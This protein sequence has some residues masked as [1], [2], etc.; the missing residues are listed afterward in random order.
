MLVKLLL[1][2][3][4]LLTK[5]LDNGSEIFLKIY[6]EDTLKVSDRIKIYDEN[7]REFFF[8]VSDVEKSKEIPLVFDEILDEDIIV[9]DPE[10]KDT[11]FENKVLLTI[12]KLSWNDEIDLNLFWNQTNDVEILK[13]ILSTKNNDAFSNYAGWLADKYHSNIYRHARVI[14]KDCL[15]PNVLEAYLA[16]GKF[17]VLFDDYTVNVAQIGG[18]N[19]HEIFNPPKDT[20]P[21]L[22][23]IR[24]SRKPCDPKTWYEESTSLKFSK[25]LQKLGIKLPSNFT[26]YPNFY[27]EYQS[28]NRFHIKKDD[29]D[30]DDECG[31]YEQEELK[32]KIDYERENNTEDILNEKRK[33]HDLNKQLSCLWYQTSDNKWNWMSSSQFYDSFSFLEKLQEENNLLNCRL[34]LHG[35]REDSGFIEK[36]L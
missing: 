19:W 30:E 9:A 26:E 21:Q 10:N 6:S 1:L 35:C 14:K 25:Y 22:H 3:S 7:K 20:L 8:Q 15:M 12:Q 18:S 27:T 28:N 5:I 16:Y 36:E 11:S 17:Y 2:N 33:K 29:S 13:N 34:Y 24:Y 23:Y 4:A 32:R 31:E